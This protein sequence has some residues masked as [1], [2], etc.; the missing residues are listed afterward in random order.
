M[1]NFIKKTVLA[2]ALIAGTAGFAAAE[3][4]TVSNSEDNFISTFGVDDTNSGVEFSLIRVTEPGTVYVYAFNEGQQG[5]LLGHETV[6]AG[7]NTDV[8]VNFDLTSATG[9]YIAVFVPEG[10]SM[11]AAAVAIDM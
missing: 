6:N 11:P 1:T 2:T 5:E 8:K 4:T 3:T 7:A 9:D 10:A